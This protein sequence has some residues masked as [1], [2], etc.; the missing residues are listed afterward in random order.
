LVVLGVSVSRASRT[1][2]VC[3]NFAAQEQITVLENHVYCDEAQSGSI[4]SRPGLEALEKAAEDKQ[5]EAVLVDD[6]SRR[7]RD[8]QHF[9]T[10]LCVFEFWGVSLISVSDGLD[11]REGYAKVAYQFAASSTSCT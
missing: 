1:R 6:S 7:S 5:F 11:T 3:R 2:S 9:N 10:L 8:N 4:C